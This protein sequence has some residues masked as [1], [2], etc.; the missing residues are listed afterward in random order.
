[1]NVEHAVMQRAKGRWAILYGE[2][3][4]R[5]KSKAQRGLVT[6]CIVY[7]DRRHPPARHQELKVDV[8]SGTI[9]DTDYA[10]GLVAVRTT[11]PLAEVKIIKIE[12]G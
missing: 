10:T 1:M 8:R 12:M 5:T 4:K 3:M 2:H 7:A 11:I 9:I 6:R